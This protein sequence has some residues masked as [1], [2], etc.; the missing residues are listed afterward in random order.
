MK[1]GCEEI[2]IGELCDETADMLR[3]VQSSDRPFVITQ[4]GRAEA[5]VLS[6][7]A[8]E[9]GERERE[10]LRLL[11]RGEREIAAGVGYDLDEVLREADRLLADGA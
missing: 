11:L 1:G 2:A 10:L 3:R 5:V 8:F 7:G 6:L 9:R 4:D